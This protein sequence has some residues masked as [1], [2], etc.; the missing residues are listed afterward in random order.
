MLTAPPGYGKTVL[1]RT[2]A[3]ETPRTYYYR[4]VVDDIDVGLLHK[5]SSAA[6]H[7]RGTLL[8]DDVHL[9]DA[10]TEALDWL[11]RELTH[12]GR[13]HVLAG[14]FI[15]KMLES[16]FRAGDFVHIGPEALA[17]TPTETKALLGSEDA[18]LWQGKARGWP[19]ALALVQT[20]QHDAR[21]LNSV[22]N[23]TDLID[24]LLQQLSQYLSPDLFT[25][26]RVTALPLRFNVELAAV[27]LSC[28]STQASSILAEIINRG[29]FIEPA[30]DPNWYRFHDLI[31]NHFIM[32][33]GELQQLWRQIAHWFA[34]NGDLPMAIEHALVGGLYKLAADY[35]AKLPAGFV[36]ANGR[37]M[38]YRRWVLLLP[39][40]VLAQTPDLLARVGQHLFQVP[41]YR[42]EAWG[43]VRRSETLAAQTGKHPAV[44]FAQTINGLF[45]YRLGDYNNAI[46]ILHS[47]LAETAL[48][49]ADRRLA[50]RT[51]CVALAEATRFREARRAFS[52]IIGIA[53]ADHDDNEVLINRQ[54]LAI[55]VLVELGDFIE[56]LRHVN[57]AIAAYHDQPGMRIRALDI[58]CNIYILMGNWDA[59]QPVLQEMAALSARVE[60]AEL[61]DQSW[62]HFHNAAMHTGRG[63]LAQARNCLEQFRTY[64]K[65]ANEMH[66]VSDVW[67]ELWLLR[68]EGRL[69]EAVALAD[70]FLR[71]DNTVMYYRAEIA[72]GRDI[73]LY[74]LARDATELQQLHTE[75]RRFIGW[76]ARADL[77][78][79]RALL[80][81]RC[82]LAGDSRW[83]HHA[84]RAISLQARPGFECLLTSR[85]PNL[86]AQFWTLCL[87]E[88]LEEHLAIAALG[89]IGLTQPALQILANPGAEVRIR[90]ARAL[91]ALGREE[92]MPAL[93]V[94]LES[95]TDWG[96]RA[97]IETAITTIEQQPAPLLDVRLMGQFTAKR[98]GREIA[99]DEWQRPVV[100]RLFQYFA[101]HQGKRINRDRILDDLWADADA[102]SASTSFRKVYSWLRQVLE[103]YWRPKAP[104]RYFSVEGE[105]YTFDPL[106][107]VR[108]ACV[109]ALEFEAKVKKALYE[110][111]HDDV[112][113]ASDDLLA[114]LEGYHPLLPDLPYEPWTIEPRERLQSLYLNGC[115]HVARALLVLDRAADAAMWAERALSTAQWLEEGYQ[116][117]MR[118]Q[119]RVGNRTLALQTYAAAVEALRRELDVPV[120]A[121]TEWLAERLRNDEAI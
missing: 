63:N 17:F 78:H 95:E 31:R 8:V 91:A 118:A 82:H 44:L 25:F 51:Y 18:L 15:P 56:A 19:L 85:D 101:L 36:R 104:S 120:S 46:L 50:L 35:I 61:G 98:G 64:V 62:P 5:H 103:P 99:A 105:T 53:E 54:N 29:L 115:L 40:T 79:L 88:G 71:S 114:M 45:Y 109:D 65:K 11:Q 70:E 87:I 28:D 111:G 49:G 16:V 107:S 41:G 20:M 14:R 48:H 2:F 94:A 106:T 57:L 75:T 38:S 59:L 73:A 52:E 55:T 37:H 67:L 74:Q 27:L 30:G 10:S 24:Y 66:R 9:L 33:S 58:L 83:R 60:T 21:N 86:G 12:D 26:I 119:A 84:Q 4:C 42:D 22:E 47:V 72:L 13:H 3:I 23:T 102:A 96:V 43:L 7:E 90:V 1:L 112:P 97:A 77:V 81:L 92:T 39:D 113:Q 6:F 32:Q 108:R 89:H 80:A 93:S 100:R 34:Q 69:N 110:A 116:V 117:L 121:L 68:R 76:R